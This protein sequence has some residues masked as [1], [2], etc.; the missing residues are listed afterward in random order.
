MRSPEP[1]ARRAL[2][3]R[4]FGP[5][6]L[7]LFRRTPPPLW[8]RPHFLFA[9]T[10]FLPLLLVLLLTTT[11]C[12]SDD[13]PSG[14]D[15]DGR[16]RATSIVFTQENGAINP[17]GVVDVLSFIQRSAS[18]EPIFTIELF[19]RDRDY[20]I[21]F[22]LSN[23]NSRSAVRGSFSSESN[24]RVRLDLGDDPDGP[25]VLLPTSLNLTSS[26]DREALTG[27]ANITVTCQQVKGLG[28][29]RFGGQCSAPG[30]LSMT[31]ERE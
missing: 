11:S 13:G 3:L 8:P 12:D 20:T 26:T 21:A 19:G 28:D 9:V 1:R 16:Y 31:F 17:I 10:R 24:N 15:V 6:A 30:R 22:Q 5:C 2:A 18:G 23:E 25:R 29:D 4:T 27:S 14:A 7:R